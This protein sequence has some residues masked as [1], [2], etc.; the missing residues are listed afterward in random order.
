MPPQATDIRA[1][2]IKAHRASPTPRAFVQS[3]FNE[4]RI[5]FRTPNPCA[6]LTEASRLIGIGGRL[7]APP[8]PDHR[9]YGSVTRRFDRVKLGRRHRFGDPRE[10]RI[11]DGAKVLAHHRRSYDKGARIE[12]PA[13]VQALIDEKRA[14]R[15]HRAKDRLAQ[16]AP[17]SQTLLIRAAECGFNLGAI[18]AALLAATKRS[19][20][21]PGDRR[22][23]AP[24]F[25][26]DL[27][28]R[29]WRARSKLCCRKV[30]SRRRPGVSPGGSRS[31]LDGL[32]DNEKQP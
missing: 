19:S 32:F 31:N 25:E 3:G 15:Q 7:A 4:V 8:L 24:L 18:T 14:A 5:R 28:R 2:G 23:I 30:G 6:D 9:A 27:E 13:H 20:T 22:A 29:K 1:L 11:V 26:R 10:V 17:A 21:S 16:A 12:D